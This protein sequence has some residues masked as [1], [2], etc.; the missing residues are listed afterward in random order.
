MT[1]RCVN[2]VHWDEDRADQ[3]GRAPCAITRTAPEAPR[4]IT[5]WVT[6]DYSCPHHEYN[7]ATVGTG[8]H[9]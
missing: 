6:G 2:C 9:L 1:P 5:I 8:K 7:S 3:D 4:P